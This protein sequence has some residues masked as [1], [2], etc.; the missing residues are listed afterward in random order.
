VKYRALLGGFVSIEQLLEVYGIDTA[1]Y[2]ILKPHIYI[3][4]SVINYIYINQSSFD[5]LKK[6]PYLSEPVANRMVAHRLA[7]GDFSSIEELLRTG[8]ISVRSFNRLSPY[9]TVNKQEKE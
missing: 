5:H 2:R 1:K 3:K 7:S 8:L 4:D 6:H 9:L